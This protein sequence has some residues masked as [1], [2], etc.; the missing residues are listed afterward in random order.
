MT[1]AMTLEE[2]A[3]R[4]EGASGDYMFYAQLQTDLSGSFRCSDI[5]NED[6]E[7]LEL[8]NFAN[9]HSSM[10]ATIEDALDWLERNAQRIVNRPLIAGDR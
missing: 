8:C 6:G 10:H 2:L 1:D 7:D 3:E 4:L 9:D 5:T